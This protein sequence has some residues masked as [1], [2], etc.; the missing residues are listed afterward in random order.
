MKP[1]SGKRPDAARG[2]GL[3][4]HTSTEERVKE[5]HNMQ[6]S[7]WIRQVL[8]LAVAA[9]LAAQAQEPITTAN[10]MGRVVKKVAPAYPTAARQL[11]VT[12]SQDVEIVV[13]EQGNVIDAK[14]LKGNALFTQSTLAAVKEWKFTPLVKD[15]QPV[16]FSAVLTFSYTK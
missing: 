10:A 2:P 6:L 13:D 9:A 4:S 16:K 3:G 12:G 8:L 5:K 7:K 11:N 15:G 1:R 14:V